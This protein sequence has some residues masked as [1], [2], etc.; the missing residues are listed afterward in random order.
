M[1]DWHLETNR[2]ILRRVGLD[3]ADLLLAVWNDPAF[4][5]HVGDRGVR[6]LA[7]AE[8]AMQAGALKLYADYG[9]GRID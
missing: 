6:T 7:E 3:D 1:P 4:I 2:M 5:Q 9:F 8:A